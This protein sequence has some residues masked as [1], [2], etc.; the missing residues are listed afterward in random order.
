MA[1]FYGSD[2]SCV[3]GLSLIDT[4]VTDPRQVIGQRIARMLQTPRGGLASVGD[5]PNWG[6][7]V[8]QFVNGKY[9]PSDI[10]AAR[11]SI[12]AACTTD[13]QVSTAH[14]DIAVGQGGAMTF[15]IHL[16]SSEGPFS[17]TLDVRDLTVDV[18]FNFQ[19]AA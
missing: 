9:K 8:R 19:A 18:V 2:T 4:Q 13:E 15:A 10:A 14:V 12:A 3:S 16:V 17:L 6:F 11:S 7:D 5:D 1:T